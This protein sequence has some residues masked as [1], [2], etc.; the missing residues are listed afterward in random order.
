MLNKPGGFRRIRPAKE[1]R[2]S[3]EHIDVRS[4]EGLMVRRVTGG[5]FA[6]SGTAA[7]TLVSRTMFRRNLSVSEYVKSA[8]QIWTWWKNGPRSD[9]IG[10]EVAG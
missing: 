9:R 10:L 6:A 7:T 2:M 3:V 4:N 5:R 8:R 1:P